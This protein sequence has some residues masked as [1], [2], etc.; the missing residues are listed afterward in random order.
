MN[1]DAGLPVGI[2]RHDSG[3]QRNTQLIKGMGHPIYGNGKNT[4]IAEDN[5]IIVF[6]CR[7]SLKSGPNV[8]GKGLSNLGNG[9][10]K[11]ETDFL[12]LLHTIAAGLT[13]F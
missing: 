2:L 8:G 5:L 1:V 4:G 12:T 10:Q 6:R 7:I 3:Q 13:V 9:F 11:I